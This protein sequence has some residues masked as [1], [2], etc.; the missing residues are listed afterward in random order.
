MPKDLKN[1]AWFM[2]KFKFVVH[3]LIKTLQWNNISTLNA[4]IF[5]RTKYHRS[6]ARYYASFARIKSRASL[7]K[8]K[9][10]LI[11]CRAKNIKSLYNIRFLA[12]ELFK[13]KNGLPNQIMS[14]LFDLS[15]IEY[16]LRSQTGF[17]LG[18]VYTTHYGF[19]SL[20]Y[21]AP[22]KWNVISADIMECQQSFRFYFENEIVMWNNRQNVLTSWM[23]Y[24]RSTYVRTFYFLRSFSFNE[25]SKIRLLLNKNQQ[26]IIF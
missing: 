23:S 16:N 14:D 12:I 24:V 19:P 7:N 21:F 10:P 11:E 26:T 17:S 2:L 6:C 18:A 20:R 22:K 1:L 13:V 15:N 9:V 25:H 4:E 8:L 5:A 3:G